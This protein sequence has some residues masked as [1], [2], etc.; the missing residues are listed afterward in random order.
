MHLQPDTEIIVKIK[1]N[2]KRPSTMVSS[3]PTSHKSI[4]EKKKPSNSDD[5]YQSWGRLFREQ[6]K[7]VIK[8]TVS[9]SGSKSSKHDSETKETK[10][11]FL[12]HQKL[13][14]SINFYIYAHSI[15]T[16][17]FKN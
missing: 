7:S 15:C 6:Y 17:Q 10:K 14:V 1:G 2:R 8:P 4:E 9:L 3:I 12:N 5:T 16:K 13:D 11:H